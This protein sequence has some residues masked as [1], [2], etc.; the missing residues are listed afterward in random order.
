MRFEKLTDG[1]SALGRSF[2]AS[3]QILKSFCPGVE[4]GPLS[5]PESAVRPNSSTNPKL[6]GDIT[7]Q[8]EDHRAKVLAERH[9]A[10]SAED[11]RR[12]SNENRLPSTLAF[13]T[14]AQTKAT[15][16]PTKIFVH[17]RGGTG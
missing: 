16:V 10:L 11:R 3:L 9:K 4:D 15:M 8:I 1:S 14:T 12:I 5:R 6:Q 13:A 7:K 17:G 2:S